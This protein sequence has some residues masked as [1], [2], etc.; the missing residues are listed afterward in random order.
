MPS[1]N[2]LFTTNTSLLVYEFQ[3]DVAIFDRSGPHEAASGEA[4][5]VRTKR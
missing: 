3:M 1:F 4:Y 2:T 5:P